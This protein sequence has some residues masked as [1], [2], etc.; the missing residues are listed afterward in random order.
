[1]GI[2][3]DRWIKKM[4]KDH[5]MIDPFTDKQTTQGAI[6]YG[7][8][9]YGYDIRVTDEFKVFTDVFNTVAVSYTHLTLPTILPV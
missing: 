4:A 8:S 7:V 5:K 2:K 9:S 1:M 6:S 3:S